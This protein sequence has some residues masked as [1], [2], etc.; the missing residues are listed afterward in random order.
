MQRPKTAY[1]IMGAHWHRA[2]SAH[3]AQRRKHRLA[4]PFLEP[5]RRVVGRRISRILPSGN[6]RHQKQALSQVLRI[7]RKESPFP[8]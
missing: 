4:P 1:S 6:C 2:R 5:A 3:V 7:S 8:A